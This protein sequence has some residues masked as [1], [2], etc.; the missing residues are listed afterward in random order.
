MANKTR[1]EIEGLDELVQALKDAGANVEDVLTTAMLAAGEI[2]AQAANPNAP[3]PN[4]GV[5]VDEEESSGKKIV[6]NVGPDEEH[7]Y[8]KFAE[9]GVTAHE[10]TST[11]ALAFEGRVGLVITKSV[12]H[13]GMPA[14]P[15]LRPALAG[16]KEQAVE[17]VGKKVK[18]AIT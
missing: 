17:Q 3:G 16:S 6:V 12:N 14:K 13:P 1:V 18:E 7:W 4:I 8:Y 5:E 9:T 11:G 15:F 10:I 2:V